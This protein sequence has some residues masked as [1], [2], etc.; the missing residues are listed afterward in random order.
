MCL[1]VIQ[2]C[3]CVYR[4]ACVCVCTLQARECM[5]MYA[6]ICVCASVCEVGGR[7]GLCFSQRLNDSGNPLAQIRGG[8]RQV[9]LLSHMGVGDMVA[10]P[11]HSQTYQT[12][13]IA[14][15]TS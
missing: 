1:C 12:D 8:R 13:I 6:H 15:L 3:I 5:C 2:T 14:T 4:Q 9:T 7:S 11:Q 10:E